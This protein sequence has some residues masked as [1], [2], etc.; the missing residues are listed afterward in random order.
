M[1]WAESTIVYSIASVE[2]F[3]GLV[4]NGFITVTKVQDWWEGRKLKP[5]DKIFFSLGLCRFL[6]MCC[7]IFNLANRAFNLYFYN[8][9][10]F[11]WMF[12]AVYLF[13]DFCSLWFAMWLCVL[14]YIK[15]VIFKNI[16]L[17]R[18][19]L[20]IPELL[21]YMILS[22]L[23]I[24]F[25]SGFFC[26]YNFEGNLDIM[27]PPRNIE[28]NTS[29]DKQLI[30][31]VPSYFFGHFLPF[32]LVSVSCT[33][34]VEAIFVH[35]R[36]LSSSITSFT[37]PSMDAHFSAI[38]SVITIE[39]MTVM[40]FIVSVLLRFDFY[41]ICNKEVLFLFAVFYPVLHSVALIAGNAKLKKAVIRVLHRIKKC[42]AA[43][44]S[45]TKSQ[46]NVHVDTTTKQETKI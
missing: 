35:I 11:N 30:Y 46:E 36:H 41:D 45:G 3:C 7:Y 6:F 26:A 22:S 29:I 17:I 12:N 18:M 8:I 28:T 24:A 39:V 33:F 16:L 1:S 10:V 44:K 32:I 2:I 15:V 4:V 37:T 21:L 5:F 23:F 25:A 27:I 34:L 13:F 38:R 19:K 42:G 31:L 40:N 43:K 14:Y 20:R 9:K